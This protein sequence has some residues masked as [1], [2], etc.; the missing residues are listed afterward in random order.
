[1]N[2]KKKL[3]IVLFILA[4]IQLIRIDTSNPTTSPENDYLVLAK[5]PDEIGN[6][7]RN[8]CYDCH[9][10]ETKYPWYSKVAP[11]SWILKNHIQEG[12]EHLN[13]SDW[14]NY[15]IEKRANLLEEIKEEIEKNEMPL[16]SYT[17]IHSN[18]KLSSNSKK[19]VLDWL[20][21]QQ[22]ID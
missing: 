11:V 18:A 5:S 2:F 21:L 3:L 12:R 22:H 10:N 4:L 9:S 14:G 20:S 7:I 17:V 1:M 13:F 19:L 6:I 15:S 16:R 8:S